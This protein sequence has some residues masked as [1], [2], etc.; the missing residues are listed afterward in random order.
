MKETIVENEKR[1]ILLAAIAWD[2]HL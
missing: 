2:D 1:D